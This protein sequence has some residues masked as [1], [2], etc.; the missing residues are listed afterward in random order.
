MSILEMSKLLVGVI[1]GL[2]FAILDVLIMLPMEFDDR[3]AAMMGA[4]V[5]RFS[6]GLVIGATDLPIP[7]WASGLLFGFLLSLPDAIIAKAWIPILGIGT[8]GGGIIGWLV[9]VW[10]V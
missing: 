9:F 8:I 5:N 6:I 1:A 10:G 3:R 7:V 2:I 4:F